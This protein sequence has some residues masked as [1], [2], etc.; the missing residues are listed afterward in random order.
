MSYAVE[1]NLP[2]FS[3]KEVIPSNGRFYI[4]AGVGNEK[5]LGYMNSSPRKDYFAFINRNGVS[6]IGRLDLMDANKKIKKDQV[7]IEVIPNKYGT[8]VDYTEY[9]P[10]IKSGYLVFS[11][12]DVEISFIEWLKFL[13]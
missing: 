7:L 10:K 3:K 6:K 5:Y 4:S 9:V 2:I 11:T 12:E 13:N 8:F 1:H